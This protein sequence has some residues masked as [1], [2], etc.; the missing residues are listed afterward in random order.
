MDWKTALDCYCS[1]NILEKEDIELLEIEYKQ[2]LKA[3]INEF[4]LEIL[5]KTARN[6]KST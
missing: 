6:D 2:V 3:T 4:K 1:G 5:S